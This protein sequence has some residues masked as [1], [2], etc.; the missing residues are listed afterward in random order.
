MRVKMKTYIFKFILK[1]ML[2]WFC[3]KF[4]IRLIRHFDFKLL[5]TKRK[6]ERGGKKERNYRVI[7][8]FIHFYIFKYT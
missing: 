3:D 7:E 5:I 1:F 6:G 2:P 4:V 8:G